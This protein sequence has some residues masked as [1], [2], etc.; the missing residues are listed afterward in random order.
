VFTLPAPVVTPAFTTTPVT[1]LVAAAAR[2]TPVASSDPPGSVAQLAAAIGPAY[3]VAPACIVG[4][5][6]VEDPSGDPAQWNLTGSGAYGLPQFTAGGVWADTP[7]GQ[8]GLERTAATAEQQ[9]EMLAWALS[10]GHASA[11]A[12]SLPAACAG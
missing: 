12:G 5:I 7:L 4:I 6:R 1:H 2:V 10:H 3:G 11:W 8:A 9:V